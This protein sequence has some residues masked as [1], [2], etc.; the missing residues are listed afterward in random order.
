MATS[1][2]V[3]VWIWS[4]CVVAGKCTLLPL[5]HLPVYAIRHALFSYMMTFLISLLKSLSPCL[6]LSSF[7]SSLSF[8]LYLALF[9]SLSLFLPRVHDAPRC[10]VGFGRM[11][12]TIYQNRRWS[13]A[14]AYLRP[15]MSRPNLTVR[16]CELVSRVLIEGKRATGV[17]ILQ[18]GGD[19]EEL[20]HC[21][22]EVVLCA[23]AIN[24]PQ[25]RAGMAWD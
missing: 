4:C 5:F 19:M 7:S 17:A 6:S 23:G 21:D 25:V 22:G 2:R 8:F 13:T 20:I 18:S 1:K 14:N 9:L 16:T 11:D 24:S 12:L 15:V 3:R 10:P